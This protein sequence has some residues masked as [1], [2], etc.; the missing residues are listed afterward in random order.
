MS[1]LRLPAKSSHYWPFGSCQREQISKV[2][3]AHVDSDAVLSVRLA[4]WLRPQ[5]SLWHVSAKRGFKAPV[6]RS[7]KQISDRLEDT[8]RLT[9]TA[10]LAP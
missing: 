3:P 9:G 4:T 8:A 2:R 7:R 6:N 10:N 1:S 5:L